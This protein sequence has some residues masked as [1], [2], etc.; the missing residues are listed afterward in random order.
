MIAGYRARKV[1]AIS[2]DEG[3]LWMFVTDPMPC[4]CDE[5]TLSKD[6]PRWTV[7]LPDI[8]M[9]LESFRFKK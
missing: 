6:P 5:P 2:K 3:P 1:A 9:V 8:P 7:M 4:R